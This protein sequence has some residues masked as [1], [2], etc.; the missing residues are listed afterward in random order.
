MSRHRKK[1]NVLHMLACL[2]AFV[3]LMGVTSSVHA[4]EETAVQVDVQA[5]FE[6]AMKDREEGNLEKSITV[7]HSILSNQPKLHRARLELAVA[8]SRENRCTLTD[9]S[10]DMGK[11]NRSCL[12]NRL[13]NKYS[14]H[15]RVARVVP[16]EELLLGLYLFRCFYFRI[17]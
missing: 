11:Q 9:I 7:F 4:Q 13:A 1:K 10:N 12:K 8:Y 14:G 16:L 17:C 6:Q 2:L 15:D 5:L 3:L